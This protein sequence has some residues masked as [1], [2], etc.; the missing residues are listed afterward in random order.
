MS[1]IKEHRV[2]ILMATYNG[3]LYIKDQ[4]ESI[5]NQNYK[6]WR[7]LIHDDGSTDTTL[8]VIMEFEYR[9][10]RVKLIDDRHQ[11]KNASANFLHLLRC[12]SAPFI[13]FCDQD[14]IWLPNK[15]EILVKAMTTS[16]SPLAVYC[17]AFSWKN[18]KIINSSVI[19]YHRNSL[20]NTL[21][22]NSGVQ[23]ASMMFNQSLLKIIMNRLPDYVFMH[24]HLLT[25]AA[26]TFGELQYID[27][28]LMYYRQHDQNVTGNMEER[29]LMRLANFLFKG[30][31]VIERRHFR[32]VE[33]FYSSYRNLIDMDKDKRVLFEAYFSYAK[34]NMIKRLSI[35]L[36]HNFR[37]GNSKLILIV[38]TILRKSINKSYN[39]E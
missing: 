20:Q 7:L 23:G 8:A 24:D 29:K 36:K 4:L 18:N 26:V 39:N 16:T 21:F 10:S 27:K 22:L 9:D 28:P 2:D 30:E 14:D 5:L 6:G 32:A 38:K 19:K 34:S 12:T 31:S 33:S 13:I 37:I 1:S 15:L 11:F 3:G 17:N 35:I 25:L